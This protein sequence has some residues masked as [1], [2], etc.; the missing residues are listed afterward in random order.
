MQDGPFCGLTSGCE[1]GV[2]YERR[3]RAP[4]RC[5]MR[6]TYSAGGAGDVGKLPASSPTKAAA[7]PLYIRFVVGVRARWWRRETPRK[8]A[9]QP[10]GGRRMGTTDSPFPDLFVCPHSAAKNPC[11][12]WTSR[13]LGS[14]SARTARQ[15]ANAPR[16]AGRHAGR[17]MERTRIAGESVSSRRRLQACG[18]LF[19]QPLKAALRF[20]SLH[21]YG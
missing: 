5:S 1:N 14:P 8:P 3:T 4:Q 21:S 6:P 17:R 9:W 13:Q 19:T 16:G 15:G 11:P 10:N 20:P 12:L 2:A 18:G 7:G